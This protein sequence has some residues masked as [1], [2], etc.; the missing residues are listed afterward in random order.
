ILHTIVLI[1]V[2]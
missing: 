1:N 2:I